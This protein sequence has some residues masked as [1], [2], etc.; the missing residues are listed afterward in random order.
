MPRPP[1]GILPSRAKRPA[2]HFYWS[3]KIPE[4]RVSFPAQHTTP[5]CTHVDKAKRCGV[6]GV[7]TNNVSDYEYTLGT[8]NGRYTAHPPVQCSGQNGVY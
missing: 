5:D 1:R 6:W 7:F 3:I 8:H 2:E 4:E